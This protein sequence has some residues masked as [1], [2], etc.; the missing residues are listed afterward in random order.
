M[1]YKNL[2]DKNSVKSD[3]WQEAFRTGMWAIRN[4]SPTSS[5]E[6]LRIALAI[7]AS[8][9]WMCKSMDIKSAFLQSKE[10][11]QLVYLDPPKEVSVPPGYIWKFSLQV[12]IWLN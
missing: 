1:G 2:H 10:L 8:N 3:L 7:M 9:H 6:G 12:Y 4:G 5:K 11:D